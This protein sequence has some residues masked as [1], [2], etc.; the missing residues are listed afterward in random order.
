MNV[1]LRHIVLLICISF[2]FTDAN[3]YNYIPYVT[4]YTKTDYNAGNQNWCI[5]SDSEGIIYF[6]NNSG[7]LRNVYGQ[8]DLS[9]TTNNDFIR[10]IKIVNDTIYCGGDKDFG[11]FTKDKTGNLVY[12]LITNFDSNSS[13]WNIIYSNGKVYAQ[14]YEF[15]IV[16]DIGRQTI[17]YIKPE[18]SISYIYTRE[19]KIWVFLK[20]GQIE[21]LKNNKLTPVF[22]FEELRNEEI[23]EIINS[24]NKLYIVLLK[25]EIYSLSDNK[26]H[27][28]NLPE[29]VKGNSIF[30]ASTYNEKSFFIGTINS[31]L[32]ELSYEDSVIGNINI[33]KGLVDNTVL[34]IFADK[35]DNI[36]LGLDYGIAFVEKRNNLQPIFN[37][38]TTY[39]IAEHN[40]L[41]YVATNKG[42]FRG[43]DGHEFKIV[44]NSEGQVWNVRNINNEIFFCHNKGI[45]KL[46]GDNCIDIFTGDGVYDLCSFKKTNYYVFSTYTGLYLGLKTGKNISIKKKLSNNPLYKLHYDTINKII[47]CA[48]PGKKVIALKMNGNNIETKTYSK[49]NNFFYNDNKIVFYNGKSYFEYSSNNFHALNFNPFTL[50]GDSIEN[51]FFDN[52]FNNIV[53]LKKG[54]LYMMSKLRDGSYHI[55]NKLLSGLNDKIIN[56]YFSVAFVNKYVLIT[57]ERGVESLYMNTD[58]KLPIPVNV[59]SCVSVNSNTSD[60]HKFYYP[61]NKNIISLK[62][63]N[64]DLFFFFSQSNLRRCKAEYRYRLLPDNKN[65]SLWYSKINQKEYSNVKGGEYIFQIEAK[66]PDGTISSYKTKI[67]IERNFF[68]TRWMILIYIIGIMGFAIILKIIIYRINTT[69]LEREKKLYKQK[70]IKENLKGKNEQLLKYL[71]IINRKNIFL[72]NISDSLTRMRNYQAKSIIKKIDDEVNSEKKDFVFYKF[73]TELHQDFIGKLK[74]NHPDLTGNDIR[75]ASYIRMN[76]DSSQI[77]SLLNITVKSYDTTRYRLRKKLNLPSEVELNYYLQNL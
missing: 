69:H 66:N 50:L 15:I 23:R 74:E 40:D 12:S 67:N 25:G 46:A 27:N 14:N 13:I 57:T 9:V 65:W 62:K 26:L 10:S 42:V 6:G 59:V 32:Y 2:I 63:G 24:G 37:K 28:I 3:S 51:M 70:L 17:K 41:L 39:G 47:W 38:G 36:W 19:N 56:K 71:E 35:N 60:T 22:H 76:L 61:F 33:N 68:Q 49:F 48:V 77:S 5:D 4:C 11:Y 52:N 21:S 34:S 7:L 55:Y 54:K 29:K 20:T 53:Y 73:F 58:L 1:Y 44:R 31:G 30:S 43:K 8:W 16:Y 45:K 64:Y 72:N 75:V 18:K